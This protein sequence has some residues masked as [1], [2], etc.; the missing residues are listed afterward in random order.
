MKNE[1]RF[2]M[3]GVSVQISLLFSVQ[4]DWVHKLQV[5]LIENHTFYDGVQ[6]SVDHSS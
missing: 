2:I 6:L 1:S 3:K 5:L 4:A